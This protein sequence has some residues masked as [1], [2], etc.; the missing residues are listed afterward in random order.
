MRK[1]IRHHPPDKASD[2]S[3][4]PNPTGQ[5]KGQKSSETPSSQDERASG[6]LIAHPQGDAAVPP[7]E[8]QT[9]NYAIS[10]IVNT[11][12]SPEAVD[13]AHFALD[14]NFNALLEVAARG[15][16]VEDGLAL[17][18]Q[19]LELRSEAEAQR[20]KHFREVTQAVIDAKTRDPDE[21]ERRESAKFRRGL[22]AM[23]GISGLLFGVGSVI[24]GGV[25]GNIIAFSVLSALSVICLTYTVILASGGVLTPRNV[26]PII[27]AVMNGVARLVRGE[28]EEDNAPQ[29]S[30]RRRNRR[31][32]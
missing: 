2:S 26:Q 16:Q 8:E 11:S 12:A 28:Q 27:T 23:V 3:P 10:E 13:A 29:P 4:E 32:K 25:G 6:G 24:V 14:I 20:V 5:D 1:R 31:K 15:K 18:R 19:V 9:G 21:V 17:V 30:K 22:M 7:A